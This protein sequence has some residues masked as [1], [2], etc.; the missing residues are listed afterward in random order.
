[1]NE[2][3]VYVM[4]TCMQYMY[5]H[6]SLNASLLHIV[7]SFEEKPKKRKK[8]K[9]HDDATERRDVTNR[10]T[11]ASS[12]VVLNDV[13]LFI[14]C[15]CFNA[16]YVVAS[17][18]EDRRLAQLDSIELMLR[19]IMRRDDIASASPVPQRRPAYHLP[20]REYLSRSYM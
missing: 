18:K 9:V 7:C 12:H 20:Q 6:C 13:Q 16:N 19:S 10:T 14:G 11:S 5:I 2:Y 15:C 4:Y 3:D 8:H 1:M 17:Q